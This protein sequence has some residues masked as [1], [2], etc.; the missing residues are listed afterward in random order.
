[1]PELV[2]IVATNPEGE[3]PVALTPFLPVKDAAAQLREFR[4][5]GY[6]SRKVKRPLL[7]VRDAAGKSVEVDG[8]EKK[9]TSKKS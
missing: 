4:E 7:D 6:G 1:M 8:G 3:C 2:Q 9:P 5:T